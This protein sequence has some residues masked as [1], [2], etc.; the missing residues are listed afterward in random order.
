[1]SSI[2]R[3]QV[4]TARYFG[5]TQADIIS[6]RQDRRT[7]RARHVAM[8]LCRHD[9][10]ASLPKIGKAFGGRDH[11]SVLYA[12]RKIDAELARP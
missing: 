7:A 1:M 6:Q 9:T 10:G 12:I 5:V 8:W 3:I 4:M 11:T 2:T